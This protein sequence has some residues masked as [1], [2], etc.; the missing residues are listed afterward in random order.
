MIGQ[1]QTCVLESL[2]ERLRAKYRDTYSLDKLDGRFVDLRVQKFRLEALPDTLS[3]RDL[4]KLEKRRQK[5]PVV[6]LKYLFSKM[7]GDKDAPRKVLT[8]G[9]PGVGKT[10]LV[11]YLARE[12]A[13]EHLWPEIDYLFVIKLRKLLETAGWSLS[14][15]LFGDL[16]LSDDDKNEFLEEICQHSNQALCIVDGLDEFQQFEFTSRRFPVEDKVNLSTMISSV[17][18]CSFLPDAKMILTTRPTNRI[19]PFEEFGRVVDIYGFT[20]E[21]IEQYVD[22][23]C[24]GKEELKHYI[25]ANIDT[26]PNM[27]TFCHTPILCRFICESLEDIHEN[28]E[29]LDTLE[30]ICEDEECS[31]NKEGMC[32]NPERITDRDMQT[33]TQL[34]VK[35]THRIGRKLHPSLKND[36]KDRDLGGIFSIL[37]GSFLKHAALAKSGMTNPLKLIFDDADLEDNQ[38][39]TDDTQTGFLSGSKKTDPNDTHTY[40]DTWSFSHLTL[41]EF[42]GAFGLLQGSDEA[43]LELLRKKESRKQNEMVITFLLGLL[44]DPH[45]AYFLRYLGSVEASFALCTQMIKQLANKLKHDPVK[46][47]TFVFET[48]CKDL[49]KYMPEKIDASRIYPAEML[50]LC[51]VL[52]QDI[53]R[54]TH[55]G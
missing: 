12:W 49:V 43:I 21:G 28:P 17:I 11:E 54:I 5:S 42:F 31:K 26:N 38:F 18:S 25:R 8:R 27:K 14:D 45:N 40:K 3:E 36:S 50:S 46:L 35:A 24:A 44:G 51:W 1:F 37:K 34:F 20:T 6:P 4:V 10:T 22:K 41:Q 52:Q 16:Q 32:E 47:A 9:R 53:C 19:P 33:M 29:Q 13:E 48:Q 23:F 2:K 7:K 39:S 15:L 55:V 30:E